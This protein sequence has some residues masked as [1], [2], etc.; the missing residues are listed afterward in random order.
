MQLNIGTKIRELR[1]R[2]GRTQD[3]LAEALGVTAQAV[4]R[5]VSVLWM[6]LGQS[7]L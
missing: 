2:D 4:S 5:W 7:I 6:S 1:R 3:N